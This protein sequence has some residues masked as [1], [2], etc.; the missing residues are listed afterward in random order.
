[1]VALFGDVVDILGSGTLMEKVH[2]E[3]RDLRGILLLDASYLALCLLTY[4]DVN[5]VVPSC[6]YHSGGLKLPSLP[7]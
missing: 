7:K 1:M 6:L 3:Q 5:Q 2:N 4:H